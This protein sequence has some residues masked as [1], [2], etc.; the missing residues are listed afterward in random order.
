MYFVFMLDAIFL[1]KS[2]KTESLLDV[3]CFELISLISDLWV[4]K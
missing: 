3:I 2:V 1:I 4:V